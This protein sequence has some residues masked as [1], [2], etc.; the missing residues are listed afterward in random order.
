MKT[1]F[2]SL[3][4]LLALSP[5]AARVAEAVPPQ[6]GDYTAQTGGGPAIRAR[7]AAGLGSQSGDYT[8]QTGASACRD[9]H[10]TAGTPDQVS[11]EP[12]DL[13]AE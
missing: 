7:H 2:A 6:S 10:A 8:A 9:R 13:N 1:A 3:A 12:L 11:S 5:L 4:L